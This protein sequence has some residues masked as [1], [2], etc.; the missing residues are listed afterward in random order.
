MK[1]KMVVLGLAFMLGLCCKISYGDNYYY[2]SPPSVINYPIVQVPVIPNRT[3][4]TYYTPRIR[5]E[6]VPFYTQTLLKPAPA[7]GFK[8]LRQPTYVPHTEWRL[9]PITRY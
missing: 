9:I 5:Y 1:R 2:Y 3:Y 7:Y 4:S 6:W 8:W